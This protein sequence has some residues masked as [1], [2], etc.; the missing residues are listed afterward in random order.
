MSTLIESTMGSIIESEIRLNE[1]K[2]FYELIWEF[3]N[4]F[5][6]LHGWLSVVVCSIGILF[7]LT[8]MLVLTRANMV[9]KNFF[10]K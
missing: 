10:Q 1:N 5:H 8:N 6:H 7:N 9:K 3:S 4:T 2:D